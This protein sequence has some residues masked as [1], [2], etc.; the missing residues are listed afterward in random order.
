MFA[1]MYKSEDGAVFKICKTSDEAREKANNI[2][3]MGYEVTIFDY[4]TEA[5]EYVE[6]CKI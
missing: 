2:A 1:I 4:D 5:G 6:F 3:C